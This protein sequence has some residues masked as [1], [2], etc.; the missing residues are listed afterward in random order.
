MLAHRESQHLAER[1]IRQ[2]VRKEGVIR[3]HPADG[4]RLTI[5]SDRGPAMCSQTVAQLPATLGITKSHTRP[6]VCDDNPF[7]ESQFKTLKYQPELPRRF[8]S[9][10]HGLNF[11]G[12]FLH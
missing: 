12:T 10:E 11:C 2:T 6:H 5:H 1:L 9:F 3:D 7:S 4:A 8:A